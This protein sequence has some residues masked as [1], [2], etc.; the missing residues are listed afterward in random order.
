M[1][2]ISLAVLML[3]G[4][5]KAEVQ[6]QISKGGQPFS[7][8]QDKSSGMLPTYQVASP[9]MEGVEASDAEDEKN[10]MPYRVAF[11]LSAHFDFFDYAQKEVI[12]DRLVWTLEIH[13]PGAKALNAYYENFVL[14]ADGLFFVYSSQYDYVS[15]AFS[16]ENNRPSGL[17]ATAMIPGDKMI[18]EYSEPISSGMNSPKAVIRIS[19]IGYHY[20]GAASLTGEKIDE[21]EYC[22]VNINCPEGDNWQ[23]EK[24]GVVKLVMKEGSAS[25]LCSGSLINNTAEDLTPYL[26]TAYHCSASASAADKEMWVFYFNYE[27]EGCENTGTAPT[28]QTLTGCTMVAR[29]LMSGGTDFQLLLL[30]ESPPEAYNPYWNGWD[31]STTPS[32]SGVSIHHPAGDIK[33]VSTYTTTLSVGNWSSGMA[34]GHW[35]VYWAATQTSHGVTEGGSSGSPL[36][37]S[38]K[39]IVGTLTGGGSYC[40]SPNVPDYY[41]RFDKHWNANGSAALQQLAPWLDPCNKNLNTLEGIDYEYYNQSPDSVMAISLGNGSIFLNW[42]KANAT[43]QVVIAVST[44]TIYANL[45]NDVTYNVGDE[46]LCNGASDATIIYVGD[47]ESFTYNDV[48][49][50]ST[51][52]FKIWAKPDGGSYTPARFVSTTTYCNDA[53]SLPYEQIFTAD[54]PSCWILTNRAGSA[55]NTWLFGSSS[56]VSLSGITGGYAYI[57]SFEYGPYASQNADLISPVFDL[58]EYADVDVSFVHRY[59]HKNES[60]GTFAYSLD[61]GLTWQPIQSWEAHSLNP[62]IFEVDVT[63]FVALQPNVMFAFNYLGTDGWYWAV[64]QFNLK[65]S[66][67][68][69]EN[70]DSKGQI[71]IFPNPAKDFV[72]IETTSSNQEAIVDIVNISGQVI[73]SKSA[74]FE[75]GFIT[76]DTHDISRGVYLVR[77]STS[78]QTVTKRLII[79]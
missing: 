15:G 36:F 53:T 57:N 31:R 74:S 3:L 34:Q 1:L 37:N 61:Y 51:Y 41:G 4:I 33:K 26:L 32:T 9:S 70:F 64:K 6:A 38:D 20:R 24:R 29:G 46:I 47:G 76:I 48:E 18:M 73:V 7:F 55:N 43:D 75:E 12:G 54:A 79:E 49:P 35:R 59:R 39:K 10:G 17:F 56:T 30:N 22:E 23:R 68:G 71:H 65:G 72:T 45:E 58:S 62:E 5:M 21:S 69:I 8:Q 50:S 52:N 60:K 25:Y 19:D 78:K 77:I 27:R 63:D 66:K 28:N 13:S 44:E 42:K 40:T 11:N 16:Q 2:F 67:V 14:P